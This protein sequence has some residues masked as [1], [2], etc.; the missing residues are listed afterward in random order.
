MPLAHLDREFDY[1]VPASMSEA[2]RP[3]ARAKVRFAGREVSGYIVGRASTSP[4]GG[5]L[6]PL[7]R[8]V[9]AEPVLA[10]EIVELAGEVARRYAGTRSD[11]LRLAIPPRHARVEAEELSSDGVAGSR[12]PHRA[13]GHTRSRARRF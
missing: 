6:A 5:K 10:P 4:H 2:A 13:L 12:R 8:V 7:R 3:G 1:A 11:V 9:S